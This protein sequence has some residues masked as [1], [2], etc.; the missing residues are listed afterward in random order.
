MIAYILTEHRIKKNT[1]AKYPTLAFWKL[2]TDYV[3]T[4]LKNLKTDNVYT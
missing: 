2:V 4:F 1:C 3:V